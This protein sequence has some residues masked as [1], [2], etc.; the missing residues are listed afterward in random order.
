MKGRGIHDGVK[1]LKGFLK[2]TE[3]TR[4]C[5]KMDVK[6][7][8]PSVNH[9]ILK[10]IV[11]KKIKCRDTL[12]LVDHIIDSARGVP[13]GNYLSQHLANLYLSQFDHW[14]KEEKR[15]KYYARYCDDIVILHHD[16][17][18]LHALFKNIQKYMQ[19]EL[20]LEIK[21]N[22]QVFPAHKRGIDF[23]GYRFFGKYTLIRKTIAKEFK[24]KIGKL[25]IRIN[26]SKGAI[27]SIMSY[28]GWLMHGN[29]HNLWLSQCRKLLE[30]Q[31]HNGFLILQKKTVH[32]METS[33]G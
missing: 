13:I 11:R 7:F 20:I 31:S 4:Y 19:S 26:N 29:G 16:K 21:G 22:W 28:Y 33:S 24:R 14:M 2:D 18:F 32:L 9:D 27:S 8:Y 25:S 6:K 1:R 17:D 30:K 23:L 15:I 10:K 12:W 3:G 5:L